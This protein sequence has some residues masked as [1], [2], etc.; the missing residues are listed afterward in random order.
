M[1]GTRPSAGRRAAAIVSILL[2]VGVIV[3]SLA[4]GTDEPVRVV[5]GLVLLAVFLAAVWVALTRTGQRRKVAVIG[6]AAAAVGLA[7]TVINAEGWLGAS[8]AARILALVAAV[9]LAKYALSADVGSL[10]AADV[11]GT[12]VPP[13]QRGVLFM[14]LK[15]G[16][17]KAERFDLVDECRRRGIEPVVLQPE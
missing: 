4:I 1:G 5:A 11:V 3:T 16:G 8:I 17:G 6:A 14:N 2:V 9:A 15:S 13:A 10:K 7:A 12:P